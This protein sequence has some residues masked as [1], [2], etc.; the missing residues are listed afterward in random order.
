MRWLVLILA[1][2]VLAEAAVQAPTCQAINSTLIS[3]GMSPPE[4][5]LSVNLKLNFLGIP[6]ALS[7]PVVYVT[8]NTTYT[9]T[10]GGFTVYGLTRGSIFLAGG[11]TPTDGKFNVSIFIQYYTY[12]YNIYYVV[13]NCSGNIERGTIANVT[14]TSLSTYSDKA[15]GAIPGL[16]WSYAQTLYLPAPYTSL[17]TNWYVGP[18]LSD[19]VEIAVAVEEPDVLS[20]LSAGQTNRGTLGITAVVNSTSLVLGD[21]AQGLPQVNPFKA[22][23][24]PGSFNWSPQGSYGRL[25]GLLPLN[26]QLPSSISLEA[27][28]V[29]ELW[30]APLEVE[31]PKAP[32]VVA[33]PTSYILLNQTA[34]GLVALLDPTYRVLA[35][36]YTAQWPNFAAAVSHLLASV[37]PG[38]LPSLGPFALSPLAYGSGGWNYYNLYTYIEWPGDALWE[39]YL[40]L[41]SAEIWIEGG[42]ADVYMP[43]G[44]VSDLYASLLGYLIFGGRYIGYFPRGYGGA[45]GYIVASPLGGNVAWDGRLGGVILTEIGGYGATSR[46]IPWSYPAPPDQTTYGLAMLLSRW[47]YSASPSYVWATL[48]GGYYQSKGPAVDPVTGLAGAS[49]DAVFVSPPPGGPAYPADVYVVVP[50]PWQIEAQSAAPY[51][52]SAVRG[53]NGQP[54]GV[55]LWSLVPLVPCRSLLCADPREAWW[56]G[57]FAGNAVLRGAAY[58]LAV[59]WLGRSP[60]SMSIY[61]NA[62]GARYANGSWAGSTWPAEGTYNIS[63]GTF[64]LEPYRP[65][66]IVP[67][68]ATP[69]PNASGCG[70]APTPPGWLLSPT[71]SGFFWIEF[72]VGNTASYGYYYTTALAMNYTVS[73]DMARILRPSEIMAAFFCLAVNGTTPYPPS[74]AGWFPS[75]CAPLGWLPLDISQGRY[76]YWRADCSAGRAAV[77]GDLEPYAGF[78]V[79][80]GSVELMHGSISYVY[81]KPYILI[82]SSGIYIYVDNNFTKYIDGF[83]I[84][85]NRNGTWVRQYFCPGKSLYIPWGVAERLSVYPWD[86]AKVIPAI[87][88]SA[89]TNSDITYPVSQWATLANWWS[90]PT[91]AG[92]YSD[93]DAL[94]ALGCSPA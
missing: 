76:V 4:I 85:L 36:T 88:F 5:P 77:Q 46:L 94:G 32:G 63:L 17:P 34:E 47:S 12:K 71:S 61:V 51:V 66:L 93:L 25:S 59:M 19:Y 20:G 3:S 7:T 6:R 26:G 57:E 28:F 62:S 82:N 10:S 80:L 43:A 58:G 30:T 18:D 35:S 31:S 64:V 33:L 78:D 52:A 69:L 54:A 50:R 44:G 72:A 86:P 2:A 27:W 60:V 79:G 24:S 89:S 40:R 74:L 1:A 8:G 15:G 92:T 91:R 16:V 55:V 45:S 48:L 13:Y 81:I 68:S 9:A 21:T 38:E 49:Q 90:L 73:D 29:P 75:G 84:Y 53:G 11:P 23:Y 70:L 87:D 37:Y 42:S 83:Y 14:E 41:G 39:P 65:Y 56:N 67:G 22:R